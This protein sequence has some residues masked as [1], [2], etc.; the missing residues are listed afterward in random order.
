MTN[1]Q[2]STAPIN[3]GFEQKRTSVLAREIGRALRSYRAWLDGETIAGS[4]GA[5]AAVRALM[6]QRAITPG[7]LSELTGIKPGKLERYLSGRMAFNT[8][9]LFNIG[10]AL[11]VPITELIIKAGQN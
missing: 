3:S 8:A 2:Q 9:D 6:E 1:K 7:E 11:D 10:E 4:D 5:G